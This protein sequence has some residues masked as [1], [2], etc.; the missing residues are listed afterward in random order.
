MPDLK[1]LYSNLSINVKAFLKK[2]TLCFSSFSL[3]LTW[4]FWHGIQEALMQMDNLGNEPMSMCD[5]NFTGGS[6]TYK[7]VLS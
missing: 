7:T 3:S 5:K 1:S 6:F 2:E 4:G